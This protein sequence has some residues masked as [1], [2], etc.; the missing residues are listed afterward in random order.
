MLD[1]RDGLVDGG[2]D[3][4]LEVGGVQIA[5]RVE[6]AHDN[7]CREGL[8]ADRLRQDE[9]HVLRENAGQGQ[10]RRAHRHPGIRQALIRLRE[11]ERVRQRRRR[12]EPVRALRG[13]GDGAEVAE[14]VP[15]ARNRAVR[16]QREGEAQP[17]LDHAVDE[18]GRGLGIARLEQEPLVLDGLDD[19]VD[20]DPVRAVGRVHQV[21]VHVGAEELAGRPGN[22]A[23]Q[24]RAHG[25]KP[26]RGS[27]LDI[28]LEQPE[29]AAER[30]VFEEEGAGLAAL[31]VALTRREAKL[32]D[33]AVGRAFGHGDRHLV[34]NAG[35]LEED[36]VASG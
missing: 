25:E 7:R 21:E 16:L 32:G 30:H 11:R 1:A 3:V 26:E 27:G 6:G 22:R 17:A 28:V 34:D 12:H 14:D 4:G 24:L 31:G 10:P 23:C 15:E 19:V 9:E 36:A 13:D 20:L 2:L 8:S 33:G 29:V 18:A 35:A 5:D